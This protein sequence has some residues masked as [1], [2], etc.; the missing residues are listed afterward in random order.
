[1]PPPQS[2]IT[3][4]ALSLILLHGSG[5]DDL[6]ILGGVAYLMVMFGLSRLKARQLKIH[7]LKRNNQK[8]KTPPGK[9]E[10]G[11]QAP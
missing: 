5:I 6:A 2:L 8:E 1:M 3:L 9:E 4:Q 11:D 10:S 7:K